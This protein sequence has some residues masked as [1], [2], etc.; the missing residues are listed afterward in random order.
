MAPSVMPLP[1]TDYRELAPGP[2][3]A[4]WVECFWVSRR[5]APGG[6]G[7]R[8]RVLPDGCLDLVF[9]LAG[10]P[11]PGEP[12]AAAVGTMTR[13]LVLDSAGATE[14]L[15]VRFRPGRASAL[16]GLAADELTDRRVS[17]GE[18]WPGGEALAGRVSEPVPTAE[19]LGRLVH[20]L[21]ERLPRVTPDPLEPLVDRAVGAI[22]RRQGTLPVAALAGWLGVS[23][24]HLARAFRQ[25][26]GVPPKTFARVVRFQALLVAARNAAQLDWAGLGASLGY[27]DQPHLIAEFRALAGL[28]P[29]RWR[30]VSSR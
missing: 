9:Q 2:R 25:R 22:R 15:G 30:A 7:D 12:A 8:H 1:P 23:R 6:E 28:T 24:Q 4:P 26:V 21:A 10:E 14:H 19:R 18:I 20:A 5:Q 27:S 13:P 16:L 17:L 3:L 11:E 29:E